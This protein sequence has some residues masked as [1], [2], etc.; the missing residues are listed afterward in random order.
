MDDKFPMT[1]EELELEKVKIRSAY[2]EKFVDVLSSVLDAEN[3]FILCITIVV[4]VLIVVGGIA[5][6]GCYAVDLDNDFRVMQE[7]TKRMQFKK[8]TVKK[9]IADKDD[10]KN[11]RVELE[12][13][14]EIIT[15]L[16]EKTQKT[17]RKNE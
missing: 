13:Y 16:A 10:C 6:K 9:V 2:K 14:K 11:L 7:N 5:G 12:R 17:R 3:L 1:P 4:I 15:D 8:Q